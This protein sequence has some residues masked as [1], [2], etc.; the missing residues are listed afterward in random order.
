MPNVL[1]RD[2]YCQAVNLE[3]LYKNKTKNQQM[4]KTHEKERMDSVCEVRSHLGTLKF[5]SE[6]L[7]CKLTNRFKLQGGLTNQQ[8]TNETLGNIYGWDAVGT[9]FMQ[10][11]WFGLCRMLTLEGWLFVSWN[12]IKDELAPWPH[13]G[14]CQWGW[15]ESCEKAIFS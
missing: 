9:T 11:M 2:K 10:Q 1:T 5:W 6:S 7:F 15:G 3:I 13:L 14:V 12:N 4:Y 8:R